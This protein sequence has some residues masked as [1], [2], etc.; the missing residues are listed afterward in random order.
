MVVN[1]KKHHPHHFHSHSCLKNM[2]QGTGSL[3]DLTSFSASLD[4][5]TYSIQYM[6]AVS[7]QNKYLIIRTNTIEG[8]VA[9][10]IRLQHINKQSQLLPLD[11]CRCNI[12]SK[13]LMNSIM[14]DP[15]M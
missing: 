12:L 8:T 2:R 10:L 9:C 7:I 6:R 15:D 3:M 1:L 14:T 5:L 4:F 11:Y 13:L